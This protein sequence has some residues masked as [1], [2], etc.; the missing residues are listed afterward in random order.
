[1]TNCVK[2]QRVI[3]KETG[4]SFGEPIPNHAT[5]SELE[6][7]LPHPM[8]KDEAIQYVSDFYPGWHIMATGWKDSSVTD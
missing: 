5:V 4:M 3:P 6:I 2:L 1:M 7:D 8:D